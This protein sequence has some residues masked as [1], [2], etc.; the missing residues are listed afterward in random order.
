VGSSFID[1]GNVVP[2]VPNACS[3]STGWY[4]KMGDNLFNFSRQINVR[5]DGYSLYPGYDCVMSFDTDGGSSVAS[6]HVPPGSVTAEPTTP[7]KPGFS[8]AS[9]HLCSDYDQ[10]VFDFDAPIASDAQLCAKWEMISTLTTLSKKPTSSPVLVNLTGSIGGVVRIAVNNAVGTVDIE[11]VDIDADNEVVDIMRIDA[12]LD[13]QGQVLGAEDDKE[14][15]EWSLLNLLLALLTTLASIVVLIA[16]LS[17]SKDVSNR[18][19]MLRTLTLVPAVGAIVTFL[20][21][22]DWSLPMGFVNSWTQLMISILVLQI[23]LVI[24]TMRHNQQKQEK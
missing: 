13:N 16:R 15:K 2:V 9:W 17:K 20:L 7:T 12:T 10:A 1:E 5:V 11:E 19:S 8:F 3:I 6:Q 21:I 24:L 18:H 22:E 23:V 14:C 4:T